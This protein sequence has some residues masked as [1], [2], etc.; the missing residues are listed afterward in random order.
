MMA[1][2][3]MP[4]QLLVELC[5]E[6]QLDTPHPVW[7]W[8]AAQGSQLAGYVVVARNDQLCEILALEAQ[9]RDT[10]DGLLRC[11]LHALYRDGAQEYRFVEPPSLTLT[12][13][14]LLAGRGSLAELFTTPCKG[15]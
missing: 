7:G 12:A 1:L 2:L 10:A 3:P 5:G 9:D 14:W 11:A 4:H 6:L 13:P 15:E 8:N